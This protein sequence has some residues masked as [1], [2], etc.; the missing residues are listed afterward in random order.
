MRLRPGLPDHSGA[1][2]ASRVSGDD[3]ALRRAI[4]EGYADRVA[5]RRAP[6]S[7]RVVLASGHGAVIA[8]ESGVQEGEFLVALDV[9]AA[10]T[11]ELR[12]G[13]R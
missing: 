6:G 1:S 11:R 7:P 12:R 9:Q 13:A 5:R 4:F 8:P 10:T 2:S 3:A